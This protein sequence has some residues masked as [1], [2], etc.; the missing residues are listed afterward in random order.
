MSSTQT[1]QWFR[2]SNTADDSVVDIHII[3]FIG[4]WVDDMINRF[5]GESIGI[6]ARAFVEE[7]SELPAAVK[8]IR[9]HI[10]SPGGD[11][12]GAVNIANALREQQTSKGRTVETIVDGLAASAA[13][14]IAMAGSKVTMA[15]NALM[16]VHN[17]WTI[18]VGNASEMRKS[19]EMLDTIKAQIIATYQWH[20]ELSAAKIGAL[21]DAETWMDAAEALANGFATDTI[22]GLQAAASL[23]P[24]AI[25]MLTI[26]EQ[27]RARVEALTAKTAPTPPA[28]TA[29]SA[30]E[31][32]RICREGECLPLA[33]ALIA[34]AATLEQVTA[35]VI[36]EGER[37]RTAAA[38]ATEIRA[39]CAT[40]NLPALAEDYIAG[41]MAVGQVKSQLTLM[42]AKLDKVE[43]DSS[44]HPDTGS[45]PKARINVGEVYA[46]RNRAPTTKEQ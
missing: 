34:D 13:S 27:F 29:A 15:D 42:T 14:I 45:R 11:V 17:P 24:R 12:Q 46:R 21:M 2:I 8:A 1:R 20:S 26:P 9:V 10:N 23:N 33:E 41:G 36:A 32:L 5:W 7:L 39:L 37:T 43:I 3:D 6:T 4:D 38:R 35:A 30:A 40:A 16:M 25:A 44:L 18:A 31:V 19:A 22:E 28:P